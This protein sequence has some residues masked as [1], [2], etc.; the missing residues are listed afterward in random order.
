VTARRVRTLGVLGTLL[1]LCAVVS[2]CSSVP[3][4]S[5]RTVA[6]GPATTYVALGGSQSLGAGTPDPLLDAWTQ[7]FFRRALP[8]STVF[9]DLSFPGATVE[10]ALVDQLP[11]ARSLRPTVVTVWLGGTDLLDGVPATTFG[12]ELRQLLAG[13]AGPRT[14]VLVGD[15]PSPSGLPAY[16][17]CLSGRPVDVRGFRCPSPVPTVAQIDA[18]A[19]AYDAATATAAAATGAVL[20]DLRARLDGTSS[21]PPLVGPDGVDPSVQGEAVVARAFATALAAH[22]AHRAHPAHPANRH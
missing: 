20:V 1:A 22:R 19:T 15:V 5:V 12:T 3:S 8:P 11:D 2:A 7:V 17:A 21:S 13:L 16:R 18:A 4:A 10:Q 14:T 6:A 9:V